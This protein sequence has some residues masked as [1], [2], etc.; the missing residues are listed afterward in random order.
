[1]DFLKQ[2]TKTL[3]KN[4]SGPAAKIAIKK[5][6]NMFHYKILR[7]AGLHYREPIHALL[8]ENPA[9]S[10]ESYEE[11][12]ADIF[13]QH[14][15]YT[16]SFSRGMRTLGHE[17]HEVLYDVEILQKSW[18]KENGVTFST[19]NWQADILLA[20]ICKL[21]PDILFFQDI[22][23]LPYSIRRNL[24]QIFPFVRCIIVHKGYPGNFNEMKEVDLLMVGSPRMVKQYEESGYRPYLFY[25]YFDD[26]VLT[27]LGCESTEQKQYD[28]TFLGS[29]GYGYGRGH[30]SRYW[31]LKELIQRVPIEVWLT[32][33][34]ELDEHK[35]VILSKQTRIK[36]RI[37]LLLK[38][39]LSLMDYAT[40]DNLI[41]QG[42]LPLKIRNIALDILNE[43]II[44]QDNTIPIPSER[45][46]D[47]FPNRI[48]APVFGLEM[49]RILQKSRITLHRH[50][51][52]AIDAVGALRL[53]QATGV[54]TCLLSDTGTNMKDLFEEDR[55][56][57]TYSSTEECIEKMTYLLEHDDVRR[58]SA[59]AGQRR[60]LRDHTAMNRCLQIDEILQKML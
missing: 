55:E 8:H 40:I 1:M 27:S 2:S 38:H 42:H 25:H 56:I 24:K 11:Q 9:F 19:L 48:H 59:K 43:K 44:P 18:A 10:A 50:S 34:P 54:G 29:S 60:T 32:E 49:Y 41:K 58:E 30:A 39:C 15:I 31:M 47:L 37:R 13:K 36:L 57:V 4:K 7:I 52:A 20:Q 16:D 46:L 21:R 28:F 22:H 45:L 35:K 33:Q 17:A 51:D 6:S 26:A 53:F 5:E 14:Y 12:K 3:S 23:A